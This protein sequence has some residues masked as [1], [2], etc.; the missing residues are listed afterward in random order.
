MASSISIAWADWYYRILYKYIVCW[1]RVP[2]YFIV[3]YL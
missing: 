3:R 2:Y 1:V